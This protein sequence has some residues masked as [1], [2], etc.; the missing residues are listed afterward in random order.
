MEIDGETRLVTE[1]TLDSVQ[2]LDNL[3]KAVGELAHDFKRDFSVSLI[4]KIVNEFESSPS[5]LD[6]KLTDIINELTILYLNCTSHDVLDAIGIITY[7]LAKVRGFMVVANAFPTDVYL[8]SKLLDFKADLTENEIFFQLLWLCNLVLVPF[9]LKDDM[10]DKFFNIGLYQLKK[11]SNGSKNQLCSLILMSRF[12]SRPDL[13]KYLDLYFEQLFECWSDT[14]DSEK[15]GHMMV[16]NK[17]LKNCSRINDFVLG[18]YYIVIQDELIRLKVVNTNNMNL[19]YVMKILCKLGVN[20]IKLKNYKMGQCIFNDLIDIKK[21]Y[22]QS[23]ET[24]LRYCL[25]KSLCK[26]SS[27]LRNVVNYHHQVIVYLLEQ[28]DVQLAVLSIEDYTKPKINQF[29]DLLINFDQVSVFKFHTIIL[30]FGY[31]LLHK[32]LPLYFYPTILSIIHKSLFIRQHRV[33]L[34]LTNQIKDSS[35]FVLW[36]MTRSLNNDTYEILSQGNPGMFSQILVDLI[37][38]TIFDKDLTIRRCGVA[39]LQEFM[40]RIGENVFISVDEAQ[41]GEKIIKFIELFSSLSVK[42]TSESLKLVNKLIDVGL[43]KKIMIELLVKNIV[44][45]DNFDHQKMLSKKLNDIWDIASG[46]D[47]DIE[48]HCKFDGDLLQLFSK[49]EH[50]LYLL[51]E[52]TY[53]HPKDGYNNYLNHL[54]YQDDL[55]EDF[56]EL[57]K[58]NCISGQMP[59]LELM[60]NIIR[61]KRNIGAKLIELF[62][63]ISQYKSTVP[64]EWFSIFM[65]HM[66]VSLGQS[67]FYLQNLSSNQV[68]NLISVMH[69]ANIDYEIRHNL[70]ECLHK[71][72]QYHKNK[73]DFANELM[74]LLNDYTITQQGDVGSKIRNAIL[75]LVLDNLSEF[76]QLSLMEHLLRIS[77]EPIQRLRVKA[78]GI[79]LKL[80]GEDEDLTTISDYEYYRRLFEYYK[81]N[82]LNLDQK[83]AFMKGIVQSIGGITGD[84]GN[85]RDSFK[86]F[87]SYMIDLDYQQTKDI[88]K[89]IFQLITKKKVELQKTLK[90][91]LNGLNLMIKVF[92]CNISIP[93]EYLNSL[94][95]KT[96]NLQVNCSS[97]NRMYLTITL[98][99]WLIIQN[100]EIQ[101]KKTAFQRLIT[102]IKTHKSIQVKNHILQALYEAVLELNQDYKQLEM[103][104]ITKLEQLESLTHLLYPIF[105]HTTE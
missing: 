44:H 95:I 84:S 74:V 46:S 56:I 89:E 85:I 71:N 33:T 39:V 69:S 104:D 88:F 70:I 1:L 94:Y 24:T 83:Q 57:V 8:V 77:G 79:L 62:E 91:Y 19:L 20:S 31:L 60:E 3:V 35:C 4:V 64:S 59:S 67:V 2:L 48:Y 105:V 22:S 25:A 43:D 45:E 13:T 55:V 27:S 63:V 80:K 49:L 23:L 101:V 26:M 97:I 41:K 38:V 34:N 102:L 50:S 90:E 12:L 30:Y 100:Q 5:L 75:D 99:H 40:G 14:A 37:E 76:N 54:M 96:Y 81:Q 87:Y 68:N 103:I 66:S 21:H 65:E 78:F 93:Q 29:I 61:S 86:Q 10:I 11:Y 42:S 53:H 92:E 51:S 28:L 58:S 17:L 6:A 82:D 7:N 73:T 47:I 16:I 15:L 98:M 72:Y 32:S 9:P 36:S 52:F 18:I